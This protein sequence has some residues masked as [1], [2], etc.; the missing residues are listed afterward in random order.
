VLKD[1]KNIPKGDHQKIS[2]IQAQ[3]SWISHTDI[4]G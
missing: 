2:T 1:G 3:E 4:L